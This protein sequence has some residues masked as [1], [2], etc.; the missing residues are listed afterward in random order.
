MTSFEN[1][2]SQNNSLAQS[3]S[4]LNEVRGN[5]FEYLI[6]SN[7]AQRYGLSHEF[8]SVQ[9]P[10]L[11][12]QLQD[13]QNYLLQ[14]K[15]ELLSQLVSLSRPCAQDLFS[16][17][18]SHHKN[19][20]IKNVL[21][22]GKVQ[23]D[24]SKLYEEADILVQNGGDQAL[25]ISLKMINHRGSI[26]TKSGGARSFI[27]KYFNQISLSSESQKEFNSCIDE[28]FERM[29]QRVCDIL[30][31]DYFGQNNSDWRDELESRLPGQQI[32]EVREIIHE[33]YQK[34][35][36]KLFEIFHQLLNQNREEFLSGLVSLCG[37]SSKNNISAIFQ[38]KEDYVLHDS[39]FLDFNSVKC[40]I[41]SGSLQNDAP[42]KSSFDYS[43]DRFDLMIRIKPMNEFTVPSYKINCS[44]KLK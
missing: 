30:G 44:L 22:L 36:I 14:E 19:L 7:L 28:S 26:N 3:E 27:E 6:A 11:V 39:H 37:I 35:A 8:N 38:Y 31:I 1:T 29:S 13:Y 23:S 16:Y 43:T 33:S 10:N 25:G 12:Q 9:E 24:L 15:S 32:P 40:F 5:L 42:K 2:P 21:V 34:M 4:L 20:S 41:E 18:S 17:L